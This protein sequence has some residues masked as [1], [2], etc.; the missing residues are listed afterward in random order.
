MAHI[1]CHVANY[2]RIV[3]QLV[4][5]WA[6]TKASLLKKHEAV[7]ACCTQAWI[8]EAGS[9]P[10]CAAQ[11]LNQEH[12]LYRV[13]DSIAACDFDLV[14]PDVLTRRRSNEEYISVELKSCRKK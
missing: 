3:N 10:V 2:A 5:R 7:L 11:H 13:V 1:C 8:R 12:R 9:A 6:G 14:G 4:L